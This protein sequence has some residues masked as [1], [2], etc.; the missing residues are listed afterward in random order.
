[1]IDDSFNKHVHSIVS[2]LM[3]RVSG[4]TFLS[5]VEVMVANNINLSTFKCVID[6][7]GINDC[8]KSD[9]LLLTYLLVAPE[10]NV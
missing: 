4:D 5:L 3:I 8:Q 9:H 10:V 2:G 7:M 1:M 6:A